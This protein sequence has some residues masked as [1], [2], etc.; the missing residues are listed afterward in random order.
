MSSTKGLSRLE[1]NPR[2][3]YRTPMWVCKAWGEKAREIMDPGTIIDL[4]AGED[5]RIGVS[6]RE[7]LE[8]PTNLIPIDTHPPHGVEPVDYL[9]ADVRLA[10]PRHNKAKPVLFVSNPPFSKAQEFLEKTL[11]NLGQCPPGSVSAFLLRIGILGSRKRAPFW[12]RYP[13]DHMTVFVP[14][15][16]FTGTG[17]DSDEYAVFWWSNQTAL[18]RGPAISIAERPERVKPW[19]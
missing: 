6:I 4:G 15:P 7:Q 8:Q 9:A 16:T 11:A 5:S 18:F 2:D 17:T 13:P 12:R 1:Q 10:L 14:R 19:P 3:L